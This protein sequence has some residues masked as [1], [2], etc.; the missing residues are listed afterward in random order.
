MAEVMHFED[1][2]EEG[3]EAA[4]KG[5]LNHSSY[6]RILVHLYFRISRKILYFNISENPNSTFI[7]KKLMLKIFN[8][9]FRFTCSCW[10]IPSTGP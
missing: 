6:L 7:K 4:C 8:F 5:T 3:S 9:S 10:K 1:F 2:K